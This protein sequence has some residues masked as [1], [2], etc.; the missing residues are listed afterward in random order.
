MIHQETKFGG[1]EM[2]HEQAKDYIKHLTYDEKKQL[3]EL[4]KSLE[5]MRQPSPVPLVSNEQDVL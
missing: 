2:T 1:I 5:Q 4:L 3:N